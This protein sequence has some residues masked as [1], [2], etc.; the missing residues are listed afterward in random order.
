MNTQKTKSQ[1]KT[2]KWPWVLLGVLIVLV[3]IVLLIPVAL[4]SQ[5]FTRWLGAKISSS[6]GGQADIGKLSV[7][8]FRG[9]QVSDFS[10]QG[11]DGWTQVNIDRITTQPNYASLLSGNPGLDRTVIDQPRVAIDLRNRPPSTSEPSSFDMNELA[12]LHDVEVR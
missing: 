8:W 5:R 9:V 4:S 7:G 6:T 2:R 11:P 1:T 12:R 3:V 10:F